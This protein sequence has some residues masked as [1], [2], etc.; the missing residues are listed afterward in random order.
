MY[1]KLKKHSSLSNQFGY[2]QNQ[3]LV[4]SFFSHFL[5][6]LANHEKDTRTTDGDDTISADQRVIGKVGRYKI[7]KKR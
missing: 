4:F 1:L 3:Q 2:P 7:K 6:L 5:E